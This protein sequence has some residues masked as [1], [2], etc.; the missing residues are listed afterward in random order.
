[1]G[2]VNFGIPLE[3]AKYL[4]KTMNLGVAVE[5]GTYLGGTAKALRQIFDK[6]ITIENS[7]R[8]YIKAKE[9]LAGMDI[10]V[11]KGDTR[12]YL[13]QILKSED[14]IL[15]WL[16]AHWSGGETYGEQD[17]CPLI[18]ELKMIFMGDKKCAILIDDAR[19]FMA[20]PPAP[21]NEKLWP[22][23][24]DISGVVSPD[25]DLI[26][27]NDVIY[28]TPK[29]IDFRKYMLGKTTEDWAAVGKTKYQRVSD[30]LRD[31]LRALIGK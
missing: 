25:W 10:S 3:D 11:L 27:Y 2:V 19:L 23:V 6:V 20:P 29:S 8:M 12:S 31:F 28:I 17:E 21:H 14:N 5:G 18:E 24:A 1:M 4:Q 9:N 30:C 22:S 13:P 16:D 15:F 7:D 26:I